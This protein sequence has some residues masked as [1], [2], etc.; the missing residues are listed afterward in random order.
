MSIGLSIEALVLRL[1]EI[2]SRIRGLESSEGGT[3]NLTNRSGVT[4][5]TGQVV[6][7]DALSPR[8][9]CF[10]VAA[11]AQA[12]LVTVTEAEEGKLVKCTKHGFGVMS[13]V[14]DGPDIVPGDCVVASGTAGRGLRDNTATVRNLLGLALTSKA[15]G[16]VSL[17]DL[18]I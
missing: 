13:V 8:S 9:V 14:C 15:A 17:V 10:A 2:E 18:L 4:L 11:G 6:T 12:P 7:V 1:R 5:S 16:D 3:V